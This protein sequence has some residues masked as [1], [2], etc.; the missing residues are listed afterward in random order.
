MRKIKEKQRT[1]WQKFVDFNIAFWERM[2]YFVVGIAI[3]GAI[4]IAAQMM[5]FSLFLGQ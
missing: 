3:G 2:F 5:R 4:V 1:L